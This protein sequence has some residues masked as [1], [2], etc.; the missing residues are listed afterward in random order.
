MGTPA[1]IAEKILIL[2][3]GALGDFVC[4]LPALETL[5]R[6]REVDLFART[7]YAD[8]VPPSIKTR[9]QE[10]YEISRLFVPGSERED[11][12]KHFFAP[13]SRIYSWMGS[14]Q[15]DFVRHLTL[16]SEDKLKVYP[17][18][19]SGSRI[20]MTD[21]FLSCLG[22]KGS[23]E[24]APRISIRSDALVWSHR[25]WQQSHLQEKRVLVLSPGSGA[26][27]KNWPVEFYLEVAEWWERHFRGKSLV[28]LG[29]AEEERGASGDRWR[30]AAAL[31]DLD[32]AR[33]AALIS[34]CD[35]YLG[36]D[37]GVT[38]MAAALGVETVALYGPT[39]PV[40]W[41]PRGQRVRVITRNIECSP[42]LYSVMKSCP[43][44][45]C[46]TALTPGHV[47]RELVKLLERTKDSADLLDKG[48]GR[49]YS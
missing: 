32:L 9:S 24:A 16:L 38:H 40:Q 2:F 12:L 34:R 43:H 41:A 18:R 10:C 23:S 20:H 3:P 6:G 42:C 4:F 21:Y 36:N 25:F 22:E 5:A 13:Y 48:G 33:L 46:L 35:L 17:F 37:S 14:G 49:D 11:R 29:P 1:P 27:E 26:R 8:L 15:P 44:R 39:D 28:V 31:R 47:I 7:E 19:P 30:C 45:R